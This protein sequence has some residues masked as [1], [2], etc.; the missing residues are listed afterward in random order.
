MT[1]LYSKSQLRIGLAKREQSRKKKQTAEKK[2]STAAGNLT[3]A[4]RTNLE[5]QPDEALLPKNE[6]LRLLPPPSPHPR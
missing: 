3:E 1:T 6:R 4:I 2:Q 5:M